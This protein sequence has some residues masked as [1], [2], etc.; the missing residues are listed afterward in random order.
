MHHIWW[1]I[2]GG[3]GRISP[4]NVPSELWD[5]EHGEEHGGGRNERKK[6]EGRHNE[7]GLAS[8]MGKRMRR[9]RG[10]KR[11]EKAR[12]CQ[13]QQQ[14]QHLWPGGLKNES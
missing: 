7:D 1:R 4:W 5:L 14:Q 13:Q 11:L 10:K 3:G 6:V 12:R 9:N 2:I 8:K